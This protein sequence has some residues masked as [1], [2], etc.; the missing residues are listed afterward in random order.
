MTSWVGALRLQAI[1]TG[2]VC[3]SAV[4]LGAPGASGREE[5]TESAPGREI[6]RGGAV[7]RGI[8][9]V[10]APEWGA[11]YRH[12]L[13][14]I[15][16]DVRA[17]LDANHVCFE[18]LRI[19]GGAVRFRVADA[20]AAERARRSIARAAQSWNLTPAASM[21]GLAVQAAPDGAFSLQLT[22]FGRAALHDGFIAA[23]RKEI[24][25]R[26]A[27]SGFDDYLITDDGER[28]RLEFRPTAAPAR[29]GRQC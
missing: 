28:I 9:F 18:H 11:V 13:R 7:T 21:P 23:S 14:R 25:R 15:R 27:G 4:A 6:S 22:A 29:A 1:I 24:E 5:G 3:A 19:S 26:L 2:I 10:L 8:A 12:A 16:D 17:A 20:S